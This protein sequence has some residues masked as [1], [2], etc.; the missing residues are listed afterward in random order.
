MMMLFGSN[1]SS[2]VSCLTIVSISSIVLTDT[3]LCMNACSSM[4]LNMHMCIYVYMQFNRE[5][6]MP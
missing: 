3:F 6:L 4:V 5:A 1:S 2:T